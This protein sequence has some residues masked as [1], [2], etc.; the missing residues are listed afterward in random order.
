VKNGVHQDASIQRRASNFIGDILMQ[1]LVWAIQVG[2]VAGDAAPSVRMPGPG[3]HPPDLVAIRKGR[4]ADRKRDGIPTRRA[5]GR[6]QPVDDE[7][8]LSNHQNGERS[9]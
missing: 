4:R 8:L 9:G 2:A 7:R 5:A 1:D 3:V 6:H